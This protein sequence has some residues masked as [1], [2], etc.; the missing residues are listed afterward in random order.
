MS[1]LLAISGLLVAATFTGAQTRP[2][3]IQ[4]SRVVVHV[5]RAGLFGKLGDNHE[6]AAPIVSGSLDE[7]ARH[8]TVRFDARQLR[9]LDPQLSADKRSQV[10]QRMLGPEVLDAQRFP[11]V[12][13]E[14]TSVRQ[15]AGGTLAVNGTL[16]LHGQAHTVSGTAAS[17][18][19]GYHG[20]FKLRQREFGITPVSLAGGTIKVKDELLIEFELRP[21]AM[22]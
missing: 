13:F 5:Y 18:P 22:K 17:S 11:D 4:T 21:A 10:Q 1:H 3:D 7:S 16:R 14:S 8:V 2:V 19:D 12:T 6:I 15:Q 20:S 9:V